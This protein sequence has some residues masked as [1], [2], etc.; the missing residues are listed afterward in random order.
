MV[1]RRILAALIL[2]TLTDSLAEEFLQ[3]LLVLRLEHEGVST[4]LIGLVSSAGDLGVLLAAPLVPTLARSI[5]AVSYLRWSLLV[6]GLGILLFPVFPHVWA[7]IALDFGLGAIT[8]GYFVLSDSLINAAVTDDYRGRVLAAYMVAE[9]LG[10]ILGPSLLSAVGIEGFA[11]FAVATGIMG[12]GIVP[13]FLLASIAVP[14]LGDEHPAPLATLARGAPLVL[15]VALAGAFM[16]DVPKS[17]LPVFSIERGLSETTAVLI[18]AVLAAGTVLWQLPAGWAADRFDRR[19]YLVGLGLAT[20]ACS[21]ALLFFI[22]SPS[23]RWPTVFVL[24]GLLN[25]F[26]LV[27]LALLGERTRLADLAS[28][29]AAV[30]MAGSVAGFLGPPFTGAVMDLAGPDALP[31]VT[32]L[33]AAGV[34]G[35]ALW[36]RLRR[37]PGRGSR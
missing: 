3:P 22:T 24:G 32:A 27:A 7:W 23:L 2:T 4:F 31:I 14:D 33:V 15:I 17:L 21:V 8:C 25:A 6:V 28:M 19:S 37:P 10:A 35:A 5:G 12:V 20:A 30:T 13:W 9:S 26:D 29:S 11:P 1:Y 18:L 36:S 16:D 34:A